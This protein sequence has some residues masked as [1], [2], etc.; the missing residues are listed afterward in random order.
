MLESYHNL[1]LAYVPKGTPMSEYIFL[2]CMLGK[3][4]FCT[5]LEETPTK[6]KFRYQYYN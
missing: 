4:Q 6:Y 1:V 3:L 2:Y 5:L